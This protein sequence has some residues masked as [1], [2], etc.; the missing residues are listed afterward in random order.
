MTDKAAVVENPQRTCL[1]VRRGSDTLVV[2]F[3]SWLFEPGR[4]DYY[5]TM[6]ARG[7]DC[8]WLSDLSRRFFLTGASDV[9][10]DADALADFL[11]AKAAGYRRTV[12]VGTSMGGGA[13]MIYGAEIGAD[14]TISFGPQTALRRSAGLDQM[15]T[16]AQWKEMYEETEALYRADPL[17]PAGRR[18]DLCAHLAT[19]PGPPVPHLV[20]VPSRDIRDRYDAWRIGERVPG[21][22]IFEVEKD[23][24]PGVTRLF[25]AGIF[26]DMLDC[27]ERPGPLAPAVLRLC[28]RYLAEHGRPWPGWRRRWRRWRFRNRRRRERR[29]ALSDGQ[30][31]RG[32]R[33]QPR[34]A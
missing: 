16:M 6:M 13:S 34:D 1:E 22:R 14:L 11:R 19:L 15:L 20:I 32:A 18:S 24:H 5:R 9:A 2:V 25:E 21:A 31:Q 23:A 4:Y 17:G 3:N 7:F 12:C 10:P 28:A 26:G 27:L 33:T 30:P 29:A 8:L